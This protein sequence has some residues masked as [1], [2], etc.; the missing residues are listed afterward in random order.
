[1]S[2]F[3][4]H[5]SGKNVIIQD[6]NVISPSSTGPVSHWDV[7]PGDWFLFH[8]LGA[9]VFSPFK[10]TSNPKKQAWGGRGGAERNT[11]SVAEE[12][13]TKPQRGEGV[14]R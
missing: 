2:L 11:G 5:N 4:T 9:S 8:Q 14:P 6:K 10:A 7:Q 1:M 12:E 3:V 13:P